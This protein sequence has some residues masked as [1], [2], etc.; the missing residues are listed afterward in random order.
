MSKAA[1]ALVLDAS[2]ADDAAFGKACEICEKIIVDKIVYSSSDEVAVVLAGTQE[3]RSTLYEKFSHARYQHITVDRELA[4]ASRRTLESIAAVRQARQRTAPALQ[5]LSYSAFD[6]VEALTVA[7]DVLQAKV[8]GKKYTRAIYFVT[9]AR[10][11]VVHKDDLQLLFDSLANDQVALVVVGIDFDSSA[12]AES[13]REVHERFKNVKEEEEEADASWGTLS[14]KAQNEKVLTGL[15]AALGTPSSVISP[16]EAVNM[17]SRLRCRRVRQQPLLRIILSIGDIQLATQIFTLTQQ[18]RLPTLSRST[19]DGADVTQ[20]VAYETVSYVDGEEE[21]RAVCSEDLIE[22]FFFGIDRIPCS[23]ADRAKMKVKGERAL[24]AIAFVAASEVAPYLL[25]GGTRTLLPLAGD[26][27]GQ[28]GYNALVEAME[29]MGKA[30]VVRLVRVS[31]AAPVLCACF[32]QRCD[33]GGDLP[34][35]LVMAPL[36][37][38]ED[39]RGFQFSEYPEFR[40]TAAE[41]QQMDDLIDGLTV[42]D[43]VLT[44]QDTFNPVLQQFYAI[45]EAKLMSRATST[46]TAATSPVEVPRLPAQLQGNSTNFFVEDSVV[47]ARMRK[48]RHDLEVCA[49]HFPYEEDADDDADENSFHVK[50]N[51][52]VASTEM[53]KGDGTEEGQGGRGLRSN[54]PLWHNRREGFAAE[55]GP[56]TQLEQRRIFSNAEAVTSASSRSASTAAAPMLLRGRERNDLSASSTSSSLA[57]SDRAT[58][59]STVPHRVHEDVASAAVPGSVS[60]ADP[61]TRFHFVVTQPNVQAAQIRH[62]KDALC[63]AVMELVRASGGSVG[64]KSSLDHKCVACMAALRAWCLAEKDAAYYN[65]FCGKLTTAAKQCGNHDDFWKLCDN[66]PPITRKECE[67]SLL[68][69]DADAEAFLQMASFCASR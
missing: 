26:H 14:V 63:D 15:C 50:R 29:A 35:C 30:M 61:V 3:S 18:E 49:A 56:Q 45:L 12:D 28:R 57:P 67:N 52:L 9:D 44:P 38:A 27:Q 6:F 69:D 66:V 7:A 59:T 11:E 10:H 22:S 43:T 58:T 64:T 37:F 19:P 1:A 41:E 4:R 42:D 17:L 51:T 60:S 48:H 34:R 31:D 46:S 2:V 36:P 24:Q 5:T 39:I 21:R 32:A 40:F 16:V 47:C 8:S 53:G 25:M 54:V 33:D 62:A 65:N 23:A 13:K 68:T 55:G 20:T